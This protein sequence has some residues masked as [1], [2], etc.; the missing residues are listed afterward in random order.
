MNFARHSTTRSMT[1]HL[2]C[3]RIL[4]F[5]DN[6]TVKAEWS[7]NQGLAGD[8]W[9]YNVYCYDAEND[10]YQSCGSVD[11][12]DRSRHEE[13]YE[14]EIFPSEIDVDGDGLIYYI[15]PADWDGHY[16]VPLVDGAD[17]ENW[18]KS[19]FEGA[20]EITIS[21]QRLTEENIAVLGYLKPYVPIPEPLG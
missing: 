8:F 16:D 18:Q 14:G 21:T 17:Y 19:Y 2:S 7:H 20:E 10:V 9:P 13:S 1:L 6:G 15:L 4:T 12:W 11:A 5:Y 3:D